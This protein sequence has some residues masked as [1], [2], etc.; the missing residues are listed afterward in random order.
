MSQVRE[1]QQVHQAILEINIF[2]QVPTLENPVNIKKQVLKICLITFIYNYIKPERSILY[3]FNSH[4]T[5]ERSGCGYKKRSL[6]KAK[7][8]SND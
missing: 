5:Q 4:E 8:G 3:V 7:N 1:E 2:E 6:K